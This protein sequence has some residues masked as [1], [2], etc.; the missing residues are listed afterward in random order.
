MKKFSRLLSLAVIAAALAFLSP[1]SRITASANEATYYLKYNSE[2]EDWEY[3]ASSVWEDNPS[4]TTTGLIYLEEIIKDGDIIIVDSNGPLLNIN[5]HLSNLT[6][7]NG[8]DNLAMVA[9]S[10]GIDNCVI[11]NGAVASI[12]GNVT[13]AHVYDDGRVNFN[14]NVTNL[15][16]HGEE[17]EN[18]PIIA[19]LGTVSHFVSDNVNKPRIE[20]YNFEAGSFDLQ[21]DALK[22]AASRYSTTPTGV[23]AATA[24]P[25]ATTAPTTTAAPV[26]TTAPAASSNANDYDDVP[27]T[28]EA[29][30]AL[31]L[32]LAAALC[33]AGSIAFRKHA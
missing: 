27:K 7:L 8:A 23:P 19:V 9:V 6:V 33:A 31:W 4:I 3:Q 11:L 14:S 32:C 10:K 5:V 17:S 21:D 22:T 2:I 1:E 12:T 13:N 18:Y 28:G 26:A 30:P 20:G 25:A 15:Y 29:S 24:A 16:S